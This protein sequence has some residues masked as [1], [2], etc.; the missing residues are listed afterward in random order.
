MF[1][2]M[3]IIWIEWNFVG[4]GDVCIVYDVWMLDI[5]L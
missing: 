3:I 5:V 4:I 1:L 2:V